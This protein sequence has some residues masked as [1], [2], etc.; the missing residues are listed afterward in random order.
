MCMPRWGATGRRWRI[1]NLPSPRGQCHRHQKI[2]GH[3]LYGLG[4]DPAHPEV[5]SSKE[6]GQVVTLMNQREYAAAMKIRE[7]NWRPERIPSRP[8]S[9]PKFV[10]NWAESLPAD[11]VEKR[12]Q[13]IQKGLL[14][15]PDNQKLQALLL[16]I[17]H[18]GG[19]PGPGQKTGSARVPGQAR[20]RQ[21]GT[22]RAVPARVCQPDACVPARAE[23][24]QGGRAD[25][26]GVAAGRY[27]ARLGA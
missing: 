20:S 12:L 14:A 11:Q 21:Y 8:Q 15:A 9:W 7:D 24:I 4:H 5:S 16:P 22:D 2:A 27:L 17:S 18:L 10:P 25:E 3:G 13:L 23:A 19:P 26:G 1:L 6:I